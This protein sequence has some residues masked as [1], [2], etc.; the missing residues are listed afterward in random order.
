MKNDRQNAIIEIIE[1]SAIE[2]QDE[3]VQALRERGFKA[4]QA[5]VSRDI[6]QLELVKILTP[7]R[8]YRYAL[9]GKSGDEALSDRFIDILSEAIVSIRSAYNQIIIKTMPASADIGSEIIDR[10]G[11]DEVLGSI[12]GENTIL[13]II[14]SI[15]EVPAVIDKLNHLKD[16]KDSERG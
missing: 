5:T 7:E 9:P 15:E 12:A 14:R 4:T 1:Q 3:L 11:W 10:F 16:R 13:L 6:R 8:T 2:T